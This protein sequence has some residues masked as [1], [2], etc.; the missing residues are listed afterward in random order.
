MIPRKPLN[1]ELVNPRLHP[2][3]QRI[4]WS[5]WQWVHRCRHQE[6]VQIFLEYKNNSHVNAVPINGLMRSWIIHIK[7]NIETNTHSVNFV[8]SFSSLDCY[9]SLWGPHAHGRH[10]SCP[11]P[12]SSGPDR[13]TRPPHPKSVLP[14]VTALS[15][16]LHSTLPDSPQ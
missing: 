1:L 2:Y 12:Q 5:I 15:T 6:K 16:A 14:L 13:T 10:Q 4:S 8:V 7:V 9:L 3:L 11:G